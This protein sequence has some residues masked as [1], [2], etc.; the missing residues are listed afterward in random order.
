M[1][2]ISTFLGGLL[3]V[4]ALIVG[5]KFL[6]FN[7]WAYFAPKEAAVEREVFENTKGYND[8]MVRDLENLMIEYKK[9]PKDQQASLKD[10]ILHRFSVYPEEKLPSNLRTFYNE[11]RSE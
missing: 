5:M 10:V 4:I 3:L 2:G 1:K 8:G 9:A 7:L 6:G 11:I